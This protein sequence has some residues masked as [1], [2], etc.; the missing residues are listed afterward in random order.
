MG[1][2]F[3]S[4]MEPLVI[5]CQRMYIQGTF[6]Q[7]AGLVKDTKAVPERIALTE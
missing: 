7:K 2:H 6:F 3:T 1:P 4:S 5:T